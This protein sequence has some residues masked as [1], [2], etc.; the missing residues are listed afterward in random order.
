GHETDGLENDDDKNGKKNIQNE[1]TRPTAI[2][3]TCTN[4]ES[5]GC[6]ETDEFKTMCL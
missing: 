3:R 5:S 2:G 6:L 4:K 1:I